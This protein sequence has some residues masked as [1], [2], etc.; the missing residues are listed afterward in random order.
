[1]KKQLNKDAIINIGFY[2]GLLF[3]AVNAL[4]EVV[5]LSSSGGGV[6]PVH[7]L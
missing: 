4:I 1:M 2:G 5:G 7:C 6:Y 3:K